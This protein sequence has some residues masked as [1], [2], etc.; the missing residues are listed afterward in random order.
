MKKHLRPAIATLVVLLCGFL[1]WWLVRDLEQTFLPAAR[2]ATPPA[3]PRHAAK[4]AEKPATPREKK[5]V[6]NDITVELMASARDNEVILRFPTQSSYAEFLARLPHSPVTLVDQLDR[7]LAMRLGFADTADLEGLLGSAEIEIYQS[8]TRLPDRVMPGAGV[9]DGSVGFNNQVLSWLGIAGDLSKLGSGVNIAIL[10]TGIVP[11]EAL[12]GLVK[13][14]AIA[15]FPAEPETTNG[16]GTAVASL[17]AGNSRIAPGVAPAA[18]LISVRVCDDQGASD[19][20]AIAAGMLAAMDA[21]AQIINL[22][23]GTYEDSPLL[24]A[25]VAMVQNQGIVIVAASGNDGQSD[26]TYPA[27]YPGVISVGAV[28]AQGNHLEFSNFGAYL[29]LTAPGYQVNAAW[30][31]NRYVR[32]SGTSVSAPLVAGAIAAAM[33]PGNG[34]VISAGEAAALVMDFTDD[35]GIPGP[36]TQYGSGILNLARVLF[37]NTPGLVDAAITDQ[38][39]ITAGPGSSE[40][41]VTVQNRGTAILVNTMVEITTPSGVRKLNA[42]SL[43]PGAVHTFSMPVPDGSLRGGDPPYQ[44]SSRIIPAQQGTDLTPADNQRT[45]TFSLPR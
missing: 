7:L 24:A 37:R 18:S 22:S 28:D 11:H 39:I 42:T 10:D 38:R 34:R 4:P 45:D 44:V 15:P 5:P 26:A 21:G 17:I 12:P 30:P 13:S 8:V 2:N 31:G 14:I 19:S 33:S 16:H 3:I 36:D 29:S 25:A 35:A 43:R 27:A 1:G 20:F 40:L 23:M 32:L 6:R 9:Q 41:Q